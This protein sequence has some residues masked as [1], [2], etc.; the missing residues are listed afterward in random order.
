VD[1]FGLGWTFFYTLHFGIIH[2]KKGYS[3]EA[4][5]S[6]YPAGLAAQL[7]VRVLV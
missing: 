4:V 3:C 7:T 1:S 2:L 6:C 5:V